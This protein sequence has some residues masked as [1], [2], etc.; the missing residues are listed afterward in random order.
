MQVARSQ[1]KCLL[2][3]KKTTLHI[4]THTVYQQHWQ[5]CNSIKSV[6]AARVYDGTQYLG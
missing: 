6:V 5:Q 2:S 1:I 3:Q 4:G